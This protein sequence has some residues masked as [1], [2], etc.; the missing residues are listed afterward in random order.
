MS[1]LQFPSV[2]HRN[3][4]VELRQIAKTQN[5][6]EYILNKWIQNVEEIRK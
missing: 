3:L 2:K 4:S 1:K 6:Y 5:E